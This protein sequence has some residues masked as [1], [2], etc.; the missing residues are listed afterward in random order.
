VQDQEDSHTTYAKVRQHDI[1]GK[2][3]Q[4]FKIPKSFIKIKPTNVTFVTCFF[5]DDDIDEVRVPLSDVA[6]WNMLLGA[7]VQRR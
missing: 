3:A 7:T 2:E 1:I 4:A 6:E 5:K